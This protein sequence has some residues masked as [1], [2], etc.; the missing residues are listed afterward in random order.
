VDLEL[1]GKSIFFNDRLGELFVRATATDLD[2]VET[3]LEVFIPPQVHIKARFLEVPKGAL[4][5]L[6]NVT[7]VTNQSVQSNQV[8]GLVGILTDK[9]L[10]T[11]LHNLEALPGVETLAEPEVVT[12]SG[13]QTQ[14]RAAA[15]I[16]VTVITNFALQAYGTNLSIYPQT[17]SVELG[18]VLDM[19]PYV[20]PDDHTINLA[21]TASLTEF[22][23][24]DQ[25][26]TNAVG[27]YIKEYD[28][29]LP[30]T[31]PS[32][33]VQQVHTQVN[34]W[35]NQTVVLGK[36][37]QHFYVGGKEVGAEPNYFA[38]TKKNRG[39]SDETELLVFIT[40]TV[41]DQAGNRIH[42]DEDAPVDYYDDV[43]PNAHRQF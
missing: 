11:V 7:G 24:Y 12:T 41:V 15:I 43:S 10:R 27:K 17:N 32:F 3:A 6:A 13:R 31:L 40:A 8:A 5:G 23:G 18:P 26:P 35:D 37:Q 34:L 29:T 9:N 39:Q 33:H 4:D 20:L 1:P 22:L 28:V 2:T 16:T 21:L 30:V 36:L 14:M 19:L 42:S 38:K 25:P